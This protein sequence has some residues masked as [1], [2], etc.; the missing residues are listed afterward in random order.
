MEGVELTCGCHCRYLDGD[1]NGLN[2]NVVSVS[3]PSRNEQDEAKIRLRELSYDYLN[4]PNRNLQEPT[5]QMDTLDSSEALHFQVLSL[6]GV[7]SLFFFYSYRYLR[8]YRRLLFVLVCGSI[9]YRHMIALS[10]AE[11]KHGMPA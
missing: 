10:A 5:L 1:H 8:E 6:S 11:H 4:T 9:V 2:K 7:I 3:R